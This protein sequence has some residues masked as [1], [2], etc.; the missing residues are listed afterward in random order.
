VFK[1]YQHL[2]QKHYNLQLHNLIQ[3]LAGGIQ[4]IMMP[5]KTRALRAN[6]AQKLWPPVMHVHIARE[7]L[8]GTVSSFAQCMAA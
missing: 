1:R 8:T 7:W 2:S 3:V 5:R 4:H 6:T